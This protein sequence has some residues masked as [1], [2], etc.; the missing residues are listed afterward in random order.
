MEQIINIINP[1]KDYIV[2]NLNNIVLAIVIIIAFKTLSSIFAYIILKIFNIKNKKEEI[3][4]NSFYKPLKLFFLLL[5][6]Y[7]AIDI[8]GIPNDIMQNINKAFKIIIILLVSKGLANLVSKE[9]KTFKI[10]KDKLKIIPN[11]KATVFICRGLKVLIYILSGYMIITELGY[12]LNGLA[13]G[14][15]IGT[16]IIALAVQDVVKNLL[17]GATILMDGIFV[18]GDYIESEGHVGTVEDITFRSTRIRTLD[19]TQVTIPNGELMNSYI[20]N[21]SRME[22]RRIEINLMLDFSTPYED[23]KRAK[24]HIKMVLKQ[25]PHVFDDSVNINYTEINEEGI[26]LYIYLYTD[27]VKLHEYY[28]I[29]GDI[30]ETIMQILEEEKVSLELRDHVKLIKE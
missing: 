30:N 5:G 21:W 13:T 28:K 3:K 17:G 7:I 9:S 29:K 20:I 22:K 23:L 1:V 16:A 24:S 8:L 25:Y 15:G 4:Q 18:V 6:I 14:L 11:E 10:M 27:I 19:Q 12:N 2:N 26:K